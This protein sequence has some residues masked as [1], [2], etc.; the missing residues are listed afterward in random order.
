M[1]NE[2]DTESDSTNNSENL[3]KLIA[4]RGSQRAWVT[5]KAKEIQ[6]ILTLT[7]IDDEIRQKL[8]VMR[9]SLIHKLDVLETLNREIQEQL[10]ITDLEADIMKSCDLDE[11]IRVLINKLSITNNPVL[12]QPPVIPQPV[13]PNPPCCSGSMNL[14]KLELPKFTG[15]PEEWTHFWDMFEAT[16]HNNNSLTNVQKFS[17]LKTLCVGSAA[18]AISGIRPTSEMYPVLVNTLKSRFDKSN[19][20]KDSNIK[21]LLN[22]P[23]VSDPNNPLDLRNH[24]NKITAH[25]ANLRSVGVNVTQ[26]EEMLNVVIIQSLPTRLQSNI[27][28]LMESGEVATIDQLL[29]KF[30][31]YIECQERFKSLTGNIAKNSYSTSRS[32]VSANYRRNITGNN[33]R[34]EPQQTFQFNTFN[35]T[36]ACAFC[37]NFDHNV[38]NCDVVI[39]P[40]DRDKAVRDKKLCLNCLSPHHFVQACHKSER[41]RKCRK[42]HHT[43]ICK[44]QSSPHHVR[45][46]NPQT[47]QSTRQ[48]PSVTSRQ[49]QQQQ[50]LRPAIQHNNGNVSN[51]HVSNFLQQ[52]KNRGHVFL[53]TAVA[54]VK[55]PLNQKIS[56]V[57]IIFDDGSMHSY[58]SAELATFLNLPVVGKESF[59]IQTFGN[60]VPKTVVTNTVKLQIV[61]G[62][63]S[64]ETEMYCSEFICQPIPNVKLNTNAVEELKNFDLADPYI[65]TDSELPVAL[66][67]GSDLYW[68]FILPELSK[69]QFGPMLLASKLGVLL[70]GPV[71]FQY[72]TSTLNTVSSHVNL[73]SQSLTEGF[74]PNPNHRGE[75]ELENLLNQFHKIE[76]LGILP[77]EQDISIM[78]EFEKTI[79]YF[80][81]ESRYRVRLPW[82]FQ[83]KHRLPSHW[84]IAQNRLDSLIK[85]LHKTQNKP[86]C[87]E[88]EENIISMY[89][90]IINEQEKSNIIVKVDSLDCNENNISELENDNF[91]INCFIPHKFVIKPDSK[92]SPV[93]IVFDGS[94]RSNGSVSLNDCLETGP[95]LLADRC[96]LL[97]QFR[98]HPIAVTSDIEK[99]FLN[100]SL[101]PDDQT[102]VMFLWREMAKIDEP[103]SIYKYQRVPFGLTS[104]PFLLM[105]TLRHHFD[106]FNDTYPVANQIKDKIYMDDL[107]LSL[108]N[109]EN[110]LK[111]YDEAIN[112]MSLASMQL[113]K[114]NSNSIEIRNYFQKQMSEDL[115]EEQKVLGLIWDVLDDD[116]SCVVEPILKIA[117]STQPTKRNILSVVASLFDPLGFLSPFTLP[118]KLIF[119]SLCKDKISWDEN[120]PTHI[121]AQWGKWIDNL[122]Q[123]SNLKMPRYIFKG[124]LFEN[125]GPETIEIHTFC[126]A[127]QQGYCTVIYL[128]VK[129]KLNNYHVRFF[130][131]KSRVAPLKQLTLPRLELLGAILSVRL[132]ETALKFLSEF[133]ISN[134]FYYTDSQN[135]LHWIKAPFK[136]WNIFVTRRLREIR[137]LSSENDWYYVPSKLNSADVSTRI[138]VDFTPEH[139][140]LW[141]NGPSFLLDDTVLCNDVDISVT[142]DVL[143]TEEKVVK[144]V[145]LI[146]VSEDNSI[147]NVINVNRFSSYDQLIKV[148]CQVLKA[149]KLFKKCEV[150]IDLRSNAE[151][152]LTIAIQKFYFPVEWRASSQNPTIKMPSCEKTNTL[153][154]KQL[155]LFKDDFGLLRARSRLQ[156][157]NLTYENKHPILIPRKCYFTKLLI[158]DRHY[159][160][161][162]ANVSQTLN[163]LRLE[164]YIPK[165]RRE[166]RNVLGGCLLCNRLK[167]E[168]YGLK[169]SPALPN[170][171]LE[172]QTPFTFTS[173]DLYGP[174]YIKPY[175]CESAKPTAKKSQKPVKVYGVVYTCLVVRAVYLDIVTSLSAQSF[176]L[177][178]RRFIG[179]RGFPQQ[180]I[181]DN[182]TNF[183]R[184]GSELTAMIQPDV[185]KKFCSTHRIKWRFTVPRAPHWNG[186]VESIVKI[187]KNSLRTVLS[188]SFLTYDEL[189]T[190]LKEVEMVV[191]SRPLS[192]VCNDVD[193]ITPLTPSHLINGKPMTCLPPM[194]IVD[195]NNLPT[196]SNFVSKRLKYL[197]KI[198]GEFWSRFHKEYLNFLSDKHYSTRGRVDENSKVP[199]VGDVVLIKVPKSPRYTWQMGRVCNIFPGRDGLVRSLEI[200]PRN[201]KS[202]LRRA[203]NLVCPLELSPLENTSN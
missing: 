24:Y 32:N 59:N 7:V 157:A 109:P 183:K 160:L 191:N 186:A 147:L 167:A 136:T 189:I 21:E 114:W 116:L 86:G 192:Y 190:C 185:L 3:Q 11:E 17:H 66:L 166:V 180:I 79:E 44:S 42:R 149:I 96:R 202:T 153:L 130:M 46:S 105:A 71:K 25:I 23:R 92:T 28:S 48:Q 182:A 26:Y 198:Q 2:N 39:S 47:N 158:L 129:D 128:R 174:L 43:T 162:H 52:S 80:P 55:N 103:I 101:H 37:D 148:T 38:F 146:K 61:K 143:I 144:C 78:E 170:I 184:T 30:L 112:L 20:V 15:K 134:V 82:K 150:G 140:Q 117:I 4:K 31:V 95:S 113:R 97:N 200:K 171:R 57:R 75:T 72:S 111:L 85:K 9:E 152:M 168:P 35:T 179:E 142:P 65:L 106:K 91:S 132:T 76:G 88:I 173:V 181:S 33:R 8:T 34:E 187:V 203:P 164:Y 53:Q 176:I 154:M 89:Q 81:E 165:G 141:Y 199:R 18:S 93:R 133:N 195:V 102:S 69:T 60:S 51:V 10:T 156:F 73:I 67:I 194:N 120:L 131:S 41:C 77:E 90:S 151:T 16:I 62:N 56:K 119:Q 100:L 12:P 178:F 6:N 54:F 196:N 14:P 36:R 138:N 19:L 1:S 110:A 74:S 108:S 64:F 175:I 123:I 107:I 169:V 201:S 135:V 98:F 29:N 145:N 84:N 177:S 188:K 68:N 197:E 70:S 118:A 122:T 13:E 63:F 161:Y 159:K 94:A 126:D 45:P 5:K 104:S 155:G 83:I 139:V 49:Q 137:S 87:T 172:E 121:L 58:I 50:Q 99:A 193:E 22:L 127:S 27:S 40:E 124:I 163:Q 125:E 115:P